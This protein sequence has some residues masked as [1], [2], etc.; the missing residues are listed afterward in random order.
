[1]DYLSLINEKIVKRNEITAWV[2]DWKKNKNSIVFTNGCFDILHYG[3]IDYLSKARDLGDK[4]IVGLN[5]DAS[6][7]R[8]K[9]EKRPINNQLARAKVLAS[10][11][12]VDAVVIFEDDTPE[13]LI[14]SVIPD[15]LVKGGDYDFN[16]IVGAD[17]VMARGGLVE[18]IPFVEGYS[19]SDILKKL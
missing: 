10:L 5:S 16:D 8:L 4:L 12:F 18:I 19:S 13:D 14:K 6:V 7:K 11:F 9:G 2:L 1:M 17:F 15:I 3:H